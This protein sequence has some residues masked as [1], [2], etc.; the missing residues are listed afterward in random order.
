[1]KNRFRAVRGQLLKKND[2]A[3]W[4][5]AK[6]VSFIRF[7]DNFLDGDRFEVV[8]LTRKNAELNEDWE[9][10]VERINEP[11]GKGMNTTAY[12]LRLISLVR[13]VGAYLK[14]NPHAVPEEVY[15]MMSKTKRLSWMLT[16][17]VTKAT[18]LGAEV[19]AIDERD[20]TQ[21]GQA[22]SVT[23]TNPELQYHKAL[24]VLTSLLTE[25]VG[26]VK[27]KD[28]K[29]LTVKEKLMVINTTISTLDKYFKKGTPNT[30]VFKQLNVHSASREDLEK[31][32]IEYNSNQA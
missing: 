31:A 6:I 32:M 15:D 21:A 22:S 3:A 20:E 17:I 27:K 2:V 5:E 18:P 1:M 30:M 12:R 26:S 11:M 7:V 23:V 4:S 13:T 25:L 9:E 19:V 8:P 10:F 14:D 24:K 28:L 29:D 16:P